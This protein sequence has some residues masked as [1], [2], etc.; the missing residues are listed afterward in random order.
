MSKYRVFTRTWWRKSTS[1]QWRNNGPYSGLEPHMGRKTHIAD[2]MS[3]TDARQ[4]ANAQQTIETE[5]A[6]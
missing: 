6:Q 2:A 1:T 4:I 3:E 5:Q